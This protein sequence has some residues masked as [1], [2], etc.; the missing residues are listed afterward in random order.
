[1]KQETAAERMEVNLGAALELIEELT[2]QILEMHQVNEAG[3]ANWN[4]VGTIAHMVQVMD[5]LA[6]PENY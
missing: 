5:E 2:A 3:Q 6:H 1:M 4:H